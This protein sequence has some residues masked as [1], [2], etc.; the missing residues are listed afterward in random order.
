VAFA[1]AVAPGGLLLATTL[2][3]AIITSATAPTIVEAGFG[4]RVRAPAFALGDGLQRAA[5]AFFG[6]CAFITRTGAP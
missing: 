2:A 3:A 1:G 4:R 6:V 5:L